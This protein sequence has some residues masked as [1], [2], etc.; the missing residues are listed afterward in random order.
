MIDEYADHVKDMVYTTPSPGDRR[1]IAEQIDTL[2]IANGVALLHEV[3][4][5][6]YV[7]WNRKVTAVYDIRHSKFA[8]LREPDDGGH[9]PRRAAMSDAFAHSI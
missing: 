5:L 3:E 2:P 7:L 6:A 8:E 4:G 1:A 9:R